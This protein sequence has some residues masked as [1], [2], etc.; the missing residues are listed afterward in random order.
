MSELLHIDPA[1]S[2]EVPEIGRA[3]SLLQIMHFRQ[4]GVGIARNLLSSKEA[5]DIRDAY[6]E[7]AA[8][9]PVEGISERAKAAA[10]DTDDPLLRYPRMLH[11]HRHTELKIGQLAYRYMLDERLWCIIRALTGEEPIAAQSMFYFKPPGL[12]LPSVSFLQRFVPPR[13]HVSVR[14][15]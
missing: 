9:G 11:P 12:P 7:A 10:G 6:M 1:V 4:A 14:L 2:T 5:A 8:D 15:G 3:P 13:P